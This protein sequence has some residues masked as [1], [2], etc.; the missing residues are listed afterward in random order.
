MTESQVNTN[1]EAELNT[2]KKQIEELTKANS[3]GS[4]LN[5]ALAG[6]QPAPVQ[7]PAPAEAVD[8]V[9]ITRQKNLEKA[10]IE[11]EIKNQF[12]MEQFANN[13]DNDYGKFADSQELALINATEMTD[14][15]RLV[16]KIKL[17]FSDKNNLGLLPTS[18]VAKV[19]E[20][21][22]LN[23]SKEAEYKPSIEIKA[24]LQ[25][26]VDNYSKIEAEKLKT[27]PQQAQNVSQM[28]ALEKKSFA[29]KEVDR[30]KA[31]YG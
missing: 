2:L 23:I 30:I 18:Q 12:A 16:K 1:L 26:F 13:F 10:S 27:Q 17:L 11:A 22:D 25:D 28:T 6:N 3:V 19:K 8:P 21:L 15:H 14:Q 9:E 4:K 24:V 20:I 29:S 7:A 5:Q 31:I